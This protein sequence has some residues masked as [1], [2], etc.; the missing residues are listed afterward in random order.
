MNISST[1]GK[2]F[3]NIRARLRT[4]GQTQSCAKGEDK[5]EEIKSNENNCLKLSF[6]KEN[7]LQGNDYLIK[8]R[9]QTTANL[10]FLL[11]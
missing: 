7:K 4:T 9:A 2:N 10:R 3:K 8:A 11:I 6:S 5:E 1:N